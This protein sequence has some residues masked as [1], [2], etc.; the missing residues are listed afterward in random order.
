[1]IHDFEQKFEFSL[2][3]RE[4]FDIRLIKK[5]LPGCV[6]IQK[7]DDEQDIAGIDY[8]AML[9]GGATVNI[10]AKTREKGASR[11][12]K[13]NEPELALE[14][15]SVVPD[16]RH[17]GKTG[18]TL[19]ESSNVDY[20]LYTFDSSDCNKF[21]FLPFQLL[22]TAFRDNCSDWCEQYAVKTQHS[23]NWDSR[24]VFVP[25]PVVIA[26]INRLMTGIAYYQ[27]SV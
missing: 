11:Y 20:I 24:A 14:I 2:G 8:V 23:N 7:T 1:M 5:I 15:W 22:R 10:D 3:E 13:N 9:R 16:D 19:S 21:F 25:A 18:W 17:T 27:Y 26:E 4:Q 12:W 6:D